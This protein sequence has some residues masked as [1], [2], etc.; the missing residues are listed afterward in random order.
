MAAIDNLLSLSGKTALIS[1][2]SSGLGAHFAK[3]MVEAGAE[4][5]I[6]ARRSD[7]LAEL[8]DEIVAAG[9]KAQALAMDVTSADSVNSAFEQVDDMIES[10]D[11]LVNNAGVGSA[12][13][14][15]TDLEEEEWGS[16]LEVNLKGAWRVAKQAAIR[17]QAAG[18]GSIINTGS[19]YSLCTGMRKADYNVSKAALGQL[20]KNMALELCRSGVRVN[21]LCPGYFASPL[22]DKE[23]DTERGRAY[24]ARLVPQR[25]GQYHELD[26]PLLL[27]AS[28]AGSYINGASLVVDGGSLLSPI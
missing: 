26:G 22:N 24:I 7:K 28:D 16:L 10:L 21:S 13:T 5:V 8:V 19:I 1:G 3:V 11:I 17:M 27:L 2:A 15:F 9:G 4:V 18:K 20:T 23:F 12:P 14:K 6:A 25:L